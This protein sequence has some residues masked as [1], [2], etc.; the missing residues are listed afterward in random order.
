MPERMSDSLPAMFAA[1]AACF[2][3]GIYGYDAEGYF[4]YNPDA[5]WAISK[6]LNPQAPTGTWKKRGIATG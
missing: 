3:L 4:E 2:M 6:A 1:F 5:E